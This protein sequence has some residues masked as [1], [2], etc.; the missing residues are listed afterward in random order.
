[1][2]S[3]KNLGVFY[4]PSDENLGNFL[5]GGKQLGG[6]KIFCGIVLIDMLV[7]TALIDT[8]VLLQRKHTEKVLI[9]QGFSH[10]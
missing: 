4:V 8:V 2:F 5:Y 7:Q 9:I 6:I 3:S 1:M 10:L